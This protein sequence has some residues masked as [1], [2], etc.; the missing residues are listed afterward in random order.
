[1]GMGPIDGIIDKVVQKVTNLAISTT[2]SVIVG[3]AQYGRRKVANFAGRFEAA[4]EAEAKMN[5]GIREVR[6]LTG[7]RGG[8]YG[9]DVNLISAT[10][11]G[12]KTESKYVPNVPFEQKNIKSKT[13]YTDPVEIKKRIKGE[14]LIIDKE[15]DKYPPGLEFNNSISLSSVYFGAK[16]EAK[17]EYIP[18]APIQTEVEVGIGVPLLG[19]SSGIDKGGNTFYKIG[20][21]IEAAGELLLLGKG[22]LNFRLNILNQK[23]K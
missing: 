6:Q 22:K 7:P 18:N 4:F 12:I 9:Y 10:I 13:V 14:A 20:F 8:G 15:N 1:M 23:N 2:K 3:T 17:H 19:F 16:A 11:W 5:V 21:G